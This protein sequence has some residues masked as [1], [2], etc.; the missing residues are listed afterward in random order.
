MTSSQPTGKVLFDSGAHYDFLSYRLGGNDSNC[1]PKTFD[2]LKTPEGLNAFLSECAATSHPF[3]LS[4]SDWSP[5]STG[6]V[7]KDFSSVLS[8]SGPIPPPN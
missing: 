5:F 2:L 4:L 3:K 1:P 8:R 6:T 7:Y